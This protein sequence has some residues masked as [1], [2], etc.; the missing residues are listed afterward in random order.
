[1]RGLTIVA[2]GSLFCLSAAAQSPSPE[3]QRSTL[4]TTPTRRSSELTESPPT[5]RGYNPWRQPG[6]SLTISLS[7]HNEWPLSVISS[8][9]SVPKV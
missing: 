8:S 2:L 5:G 6:D 9:A 1:M 7:H 4:D 3:E